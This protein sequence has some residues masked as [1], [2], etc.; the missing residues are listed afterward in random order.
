[1]FC[2]MGG[3]YIDRAVQWSSALCR[4]VKSGAVGGRVA[5]GPYL[6]LPIVGGPS[7]ACRPPS[8]PPLPFP[9]R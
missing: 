5:M 6:L 3:S 9:F 2:Q 8:L 7:P 4:I 1:M